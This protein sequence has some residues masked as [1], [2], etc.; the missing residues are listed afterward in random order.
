MYYKQNMK[1]EA[2]NVRND[3]GALDGRVM[4]PDG[5]LNLQKGLL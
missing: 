5:Q 1:Y 3:S 2:S 4:H